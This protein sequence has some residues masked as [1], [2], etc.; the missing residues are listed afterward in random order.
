M[1]A[2][3]P[4]TGVEDRFP[5]CGFSGRSNVVSDPF[6]PRF[7]MKEGRW[8]LVDGNPVPDPASVDLGDYWIDPRKAEEPLEKDG[9]YHLRRLP[10]PEDGKSIDPN[11][12]KLSFGRF[13]YAPE[14]M[15][16]HPSGYVVGLSH[17]FHKIQVARLERDGA[18]DDKL[19]VARVYSGKGTNFDGRGGRPGLLVQPIAVTCTYDGTLLILENLRSESFTRARVQAFDVQGNPV[20]AFRD[21]ADRPSPFLEL[22]AENRTYLDVAAVGGKSRT[23]VFVLYYKGRG[24]KASDYHL[25]VFQTGDAKPPRNPLLTTGGVSAARIAADMWN[26]VYALN[27]A[28]TT[29]GAGH[30]AG[31][32]SEGTGPAGRTVPSLSAWVPGK[33]G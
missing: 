15:A 25:S 23:Y 6:P 5:T 20:E 7:L 11:T 22:P 12:A 9:G 17:E 1:T 10:K 28:M 27:Y 26:T 30:P 2:G 19:P 16:I 18:A 29:D 21:G 31:P 3:I 13:Q 8:V 24:A 4:G 32:K 33:R 14:S